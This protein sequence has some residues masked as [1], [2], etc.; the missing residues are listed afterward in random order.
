MRDE[1]KTR[2]WS[3]VRRWEAGGDNTEFEAVVDDIINQNTVNNMTAI[4]E[5]VAEM[6]RRRAIEY[7]LRKDEGPVADAKGGGQ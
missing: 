5:R 3:A 6:C 1:D 7:Q 4:G 2:F